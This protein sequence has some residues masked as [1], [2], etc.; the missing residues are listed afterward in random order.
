MICVKDVKEK[1]KYLSEHH[2]LFKMMQWNLVLI[3]QS[4]LVWMQSHITS[5]TDTLPHICA[6]SSQGFCAQISEMVHE[7][8]TSEDNHLTMTDTQ[9]TIIIKS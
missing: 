3:L 2:L 8:A 6:G 9:C 7:H 5:N 4:G 1:E